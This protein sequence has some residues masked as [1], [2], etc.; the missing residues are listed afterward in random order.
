[1]F[2]NTINAGGA[3]DGGTSTSNFQVPTAKLKPVQ[4]MQCAVASGQWG[5]WVF[6][7]SLKLAFYITLIIIRQQGDLF[8]AGSQV[9]WIQLA[10]SGDGGIQSTGC[11]ST[12]AVENWYS[13]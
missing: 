7:I 8:R 9:Q 4:W 2:V 10:R 3:D 13:S 11:V 1:M 6:K 5:Y 12:R